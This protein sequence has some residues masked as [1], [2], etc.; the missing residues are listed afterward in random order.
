MRCPFQP[1]APVG[2]AVFQ[3]S[4]DPFREDFSE[5]RAGSAAVAMA[6]RRESD[7]MGA[8][9][10]ARVGG[11]SGIMIVDIQEAADLVPPSAGYVQHVSHRPAPHPLT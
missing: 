11:F 9:A 8:P 2:R 3:F 4:R 6:D 5:T 7:P 1:I 10:P